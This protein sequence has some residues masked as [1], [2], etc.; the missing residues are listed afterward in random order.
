MVHNLL[1][2]S[3]TKQA[4]AFAKSARFPLIFSLTSNV[5]FSTY[6]KKSDTDKIVLKGKGK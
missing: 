3:S 5:A 4:N 2:Q 6:D 1:N